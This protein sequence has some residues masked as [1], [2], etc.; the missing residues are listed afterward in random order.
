[1]GQSYVK[2]QLRHSRNQLL[3]NFNFYSFLILLQ[4]L[5][6]FTTGNKIIHELHNLQKFTIYKFKRLTMPPKT[7]AT[8]IGDPKKVFHL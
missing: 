6:T 1:M 8:Q 2:R 4:M 7:I 3:I 5:D